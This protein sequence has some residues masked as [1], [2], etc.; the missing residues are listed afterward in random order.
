ME[1]VYFFI[2]SGQRQWTLQNCQRQA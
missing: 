1:N 2:G